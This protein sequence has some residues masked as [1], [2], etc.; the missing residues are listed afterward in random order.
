MF[1][2]TAKFYYKHDSTGAFGAV[3]IMSIVEALWVGEIF[4]MIMRLFVSLDEIANY[5]LPAGLTGGRILVGIG[6]ILFGINY[7]YYKGK[8]ETFSQM[9]E[10]PGARANWRWKGALV[11]VG[12]FSPIIVFLLLTVVFGR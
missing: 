4:I 10:T 8:Y 7:W 11:V 2:R 9:W 1:F 5:E 6:A 12:L 3:L